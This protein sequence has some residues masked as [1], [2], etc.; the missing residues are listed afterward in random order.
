ML[1]N[2]RSRPPALITK[3][4]FQQCPPN[5]ML[6]NPAKLD[7]FYCTFFVCKILVKSYGLYVEICQI[8][9]QHLR[10]DEY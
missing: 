3:I 6:L 9:T 5:R 1:K 2:R 7:K 8:A 4:N 10:P